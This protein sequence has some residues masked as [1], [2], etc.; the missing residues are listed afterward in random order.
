M[1]I[2]GGEIPILNNDTRFESVP[3]NISFPK[4]PILYT[5]PK[6]KHNNQVTPILGHRTHGVKGW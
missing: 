6:K 4:H 1:A 3:H 2:M 5:P